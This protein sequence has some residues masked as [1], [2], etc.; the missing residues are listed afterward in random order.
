[1]E[2]QVEHVP[3]LPVGPEDV[4]GAGRLEPLGRRIDDVLERP[5]EH[6]RSDRD[7]REGQQDQ[8]AHQAV[9]PAEEPGDH[10]ADALDL[11]AQPRPPDVLDE[12]RARVDRHVRT[13]GS[14]RL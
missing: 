6:F 11:E 7:H 14:S 3:T 5:D 12:H 8:P 4:R 9:P 10:V 1:V 13:R 2:G